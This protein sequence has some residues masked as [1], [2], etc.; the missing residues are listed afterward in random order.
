MAEK[1]NKSQN[2]CSIFK[3][4]GVARLK[5][6]EIDARNVFCLF[7]VQ[8]VSPARKWNAK[9]SLF[10]ISR[11]ISIVLAYFRTQSASLAPEHAKNGL[12]SSHKT[13]G[14]KNSWAEIF[15][16]NRFLRATALTNARKSGFTFLRWKILA[17]KIAKS[18]KTE[19][20]R[21]FIEKI[22]KV[23]KSRIWPSFLDTFFEVCDNSRGTSKSGLFTDFGPP[24]N[25][26]FGPFLLWAKHF[27]FGQNRCF[28]AKKWRFF[29]QKVT[30]FFGHFLGKVNFFL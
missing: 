24:K 15:W 23:R 17:Q 30:P 4:S 14:Q 6:E 22:Q 11:T 19:K 2:A 26:I 1:C 16:K 12:F 10:F 5:I 8:K 21:F 13:F 29:V 25:T 7:F 9:I 27:I 3:I 20:R 18:K 28:L